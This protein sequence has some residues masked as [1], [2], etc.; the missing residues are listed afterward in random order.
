M[1]YIKFNYLREQW[2]EH[3]VLVETLKLEKKIFSKYAIFCHN[4]EEQFRSR[5]SVINQAYGKKM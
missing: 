1:V 3:L 2:T 5:G 4:F